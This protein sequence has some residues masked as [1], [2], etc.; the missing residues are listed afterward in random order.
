MD[1]QMRRRGVQQPA[2]ELIVKLLARDPAFPG[3]GVAKASALWEAFGQELFPI[4]DKGDPGP[5]QAILGTDIAGTLV[6]AWADRKEDDQVLEWLARH[7]F[8][9][10][11]A[12][13]LIRI[14]GAAAIEKLEENPYRMLAFASWDS[15][16]RAATSLK[17]PHDDPRRLVAAVEAVCYARLDSKH[18]LTSPSLL[19]SETSRLLRGTTE[20]ADS[21]IGLAS[22]EYAIL[23]AH[24]GWQPL[25][26]AVMERYVGDRLRELISESVSNQPTLMSRPPAV[27]L[28]SKLLSDFER[29]EGIALTVEQR[30]A[31][32]IVISNRLSL[33]TGGAGVGKTAVLKAV[34]RICDHQGRQI[35]Q[36]ALS[37]RAARR[38]EE[39]TGRPAMT[40]AAFLNGSRNRSL[41][42]VDGGALLIIDEASM[43]D[44]PLMYRI[45]RACPPGLRFALVGDPYQLPPIGFGLVFH[46]LAG[47]R[48]IPQI[49]LIQIH[50]QAHGTGIPI[51]ANAIRQGIVPHIPHF[52]GKKP[53]LSF[54][55]ADAGHIVDSILDLSKKLGGVDNV[56]ILA[57]TKRS[58]AGV[59][60]I[61]AAFHEVVSP[62]KM[63]VGG[64]PF[65]END[66][67]ICLVNDYQ[68]GLQ[69]GSLG[70]VVTRSA[71]GLI[72]DFQGSRHSFGAP[73]LQN[74][75]LAYAI[76]V[77]KSQGSQ[78][79]RVIVPITRSRILDRTLVYT[80]ITRAVEQVVLVGSRRTLELAITSPPFAHLRQTGLA[81]TLKTQLSNSARI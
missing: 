29:A 5:L 24:G 33:I 52:E 68:R 25:G 3:I 69:N 41:R 8:G 30:K 58:V 34:H 21:A 56:Q 37:G 51:I 81:S 50:R 45:F 55:A 60:A 15:V 19:A 70:R 27:G 39:A 54:L 47:C 14:W 1:I 42:I 80:A 13:K 75:A 23:Q 66:P 57:P 65:A 17:V 10:R 43:L 26:P 31:V 76:T 6:S 73:E 7:G 20:L 61:N 63:R 18:T 12:R 16:D 59:E 44:L 38:I 46:L 4:L 74:L 22:G 40:I 36:M 67:V 64:Q 9:A 11:L 53:G 62:G 49:E 48:S 72:G 35:V 71:G 77:H 32:E 79:R 78:F 28:T 2:G